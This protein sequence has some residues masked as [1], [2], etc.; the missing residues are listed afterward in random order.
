MILFEELAVEHARP[1]RFSP[2]GFE[3]PGFWKPLL[4]LLVRGDEVL[5]TSGWQVLTENAW[6]AYSGSDTSLKV[7]G[8]DRYRLK[9]PRFSLISTGQELTYTR[10]LDRSP[11]KAISLG[12]VSVTC[13]IPLEDVGVG[14]RV[15][16]DEGRWV[17]LSG[18]SV[19][20]DR[21]GE[22]RLKRVRLYAEGEAGL[23]RGFR[24]ETVELSDG[25]LAVKAQSVLTLDMLS[26]IERGELNY[27]H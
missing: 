24:P 12:D 13:Y 1:K 26:K 15:E 14:H 8:K 25:T 10:A 20:R 11:R 9:L 27:G 6:Q 23:E 4:G 2:D 16:V 22:I 21:N 5:T 17:A 7:I 3:N 18:S 19:P